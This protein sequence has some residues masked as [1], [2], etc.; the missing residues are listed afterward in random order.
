MILASVLSVCSDKSIR[1]WNFNT[2]QE[3]AQFQGYSN[4]VNSICFS[5]DGTLLASSSDDYSI[6][7]QEKVLVSMLLYRWYYMMVLHQHLVVQITLFCY[8]ILRLEKKKLKWIVINIKFYQFASIL[9]IQYQHIVMMI[10]LSVYGMF[11]QDNEKLNYMVILVRQ[12]HYASLP[13]VPHQHLVVEIT[14]SFCGT[15]RQDKKPDWMVIVTQSAH[16]VL[17]LMVL[18]Y[19]LVVKIA[20]S[21]YGMLRLNNKFNPHEQIKKLLYYNLKPNYFKISLFQNFVFNQ[22]IFKSP[23]IFLF[24]LF[25]NQQYF[26]HK[27]PLISKDNFRIDQAEIQKHF[28]NKKEVFLWKIKREVDLNISICCFF[29]HK[30]INS[31]ALCYIILNK[32]KIFYKYCLKSMNYYEY[33]FLLSLFQLRFRNFKLEKIIIEIIKS[34][35]NQNS[36][37]IQLRENQSNINKIL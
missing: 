8:G 13:I 34:F 20:R 24:S 18:P 11:R 30:I 7:L 4:Q 25:E 17:L 1:L 22:T 31:S 29:F 15:L 2:G 33:K 35:K 9:K 10:L 3:K 12:I 23:L 16:Y 21:V 5:P 27:K 37:Y 26:K 19:H 14:L 36:E 28:L 32:V 6:C